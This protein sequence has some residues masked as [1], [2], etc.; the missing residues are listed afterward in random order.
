MGEIFITVCE[1]RKKYYSIKSPPPPTQEGQQIIV[2]RTA[3]KRGL[4]LK[5]SVQ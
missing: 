2:R 5:G 3:L 1:F 4:V